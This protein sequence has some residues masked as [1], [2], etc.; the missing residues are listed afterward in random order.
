[1]EIQHKR[2]YV[3]WFLEA[4]KLKRPDTARIL[5]LILN[6]EQLLSRVQLV[7]S[8]RFLPAA[9]LISSRDAKTVSYLLKLDDVFYENIDEFIE[10]LLKTRDE[11]IYVCLSFNREFACVYCPTKATQPPRR[12]Q[13]MRLIDE[14]LDR[15]DQSEFIR[16]SRELKDL[17]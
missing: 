1:M 17:G 14:T 6:D 15:K 11:I 2:A 8:V 13:I 7:D 5:R 3:S 12:Q 16:L 9:V 4:F 10:G